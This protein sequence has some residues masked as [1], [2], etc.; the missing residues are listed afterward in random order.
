V[1][2]GRSLL[3]YS[4]WP[5]GYHNREAERK[6][7]AFAAAGYDTVY[8]AGVGIRNPRASTLGKAADRLVRGLA[9]RDAGG[10]TAGSGL[11][12]G[13]L[14]VV[15]PRQLA[16]VRRA[17]A[18]WVRRRL[19]GLLAPG[20]VAWVRWPTP[21]LVD[22]LPSLQPAAVVYECVDGYHDSPGMTGAWRA[23]HEAAERALVALA[24]AVVTPSEHLAD[25]FRPSGVRVELVPHG[26]DL[27][28]FPFVP[29]PPASRS[30]P[31]VIGFVGTLDYK[32][33]LPFLRHV[34][35]QRPAWRIRLIGPVQE[36]F[37]PAALADLPNVSVEPP[38][39]YEQVAAAIASFDASMMPYYD[40][41]MYRSSDPLKNLEIMAVG[42]PAVA[43]PTRALE[44]HADLLEL[45]TT[46]QEFLAG[47]D[48]ALA[49]DSLELARRRRARAEQ[50]SWDLRLRDLLDL[51]HSLN[52][53]P[54]PADERVET[55]RM[56]DSR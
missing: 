33:D 32:L 15:P 46:P 7:E 23:R 24:D 25:R 30:R 39:P 51:L 48:R 26:V 8:V 5:L 53:G 45:A 2:S 52:V 14:L 3:F 20:A 4:A 41:P 16:P 29:P 28:R 43:R 19:S 34:A 36:G 47:I 50:E 6:A 22:V 37:D 13:S 42:R 1:V 49:T 55:H 18:R 10:P 40:A 11:R 31:P 44:R 17:N 56:T 54:A 35:E 12:E 21:E 9:R 27:A 38:I